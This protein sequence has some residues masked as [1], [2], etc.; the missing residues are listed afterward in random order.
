M[1]S[2][3]VIAG[4]IVGVILLLAAVGGVYYYYLPYRRYNADTVWV[5]T[6]IEESKDTT[7]QT[8]LENCEKMTTCY[9]A[10]HSTDQKC[11]LF[12]NGVAKKSTG[13]GIPTYTWI[14]PKA[15]PTK[16]D[17]VAF[18]ATEASDGVILKCPTGKYIRL[19][20]ATFNADDK[21]SPCKAFNILPALKKWIGTNSSEVGIIPAG[22]VGEILV[23]EGLADPCPGS[24]KRLSGTYFC[25]A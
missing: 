11:R 4:A 20:T 8:C 9:A 19:E 7:S 23:P 12:K 6:M 22:V 3:T 25:E 10:E 1:P 24:L 21:S 18:S 17:P 2:N 15:N 13:I 16:D 14:K 5:G